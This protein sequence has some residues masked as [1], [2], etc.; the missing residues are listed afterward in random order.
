MTRTA[1]ILVVCISGLAASAGCS[2]YARGPE[3]YRTA[4]RRVLER[5]QPEVEACYKHSYEQDA[6]A[7]GRVRV[8]FEVAAKTG[9]VIK[10]S[11][12]PADTTANEALQQCV[13]ASLEGLRL[14][15]PDQRTGAAT[16]T[17]DF[18]R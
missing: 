15:P 14:D 3:D 1:A 2:F 9:D 8:S 12:V 4:V 16:F 10:P 11:V 17:W 5:K 18:S 13:L 7:Q 6:T